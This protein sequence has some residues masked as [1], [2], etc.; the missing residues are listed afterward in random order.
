MNFEKIVWSVKEFEELT[1][2]ELYDIMNLRQEVFVVEQDCPYI[3]AD[4]KDLK[5]IQVNGYYKNKLVAHARIVAPGVSYK[6]ASIGRVATSLMFRKVGLGK[7]LM[8][9]SIL[10][11]ENKYKRTSCRISAQT[12][13][14]KFYSEFGFEVCSE[15]YLEDNLPHFEMFRT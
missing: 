7:L 10:A 14:L 4:Y 11:L 2:L 8:T 12:Y 13:L 15:E 1:I 9:K 5:S 3:D 6:E